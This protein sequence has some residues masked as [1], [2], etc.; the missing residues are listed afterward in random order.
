MTTVAESA[1]SERTDGSRNVTYWMDGGFEINP[2][3]DYFEGSS[4]Y[5][6]PPASIVFVSLERR[7][8]WNVQCRAGLSRQSQVR[9]RNSWSR[10]E[11]ESGDSHPPHPETATDPAAPSNLRAN[12]SRLANLNLSPALS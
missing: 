7:T 9:R 1:P 12:P 4:S 6:L 5:L 3:D 11:H 8:E 10:R 2:T